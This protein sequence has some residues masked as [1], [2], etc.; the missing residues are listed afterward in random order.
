MSP[1]SKTLPLSSLPLYWTYMC[2]EGGGAN[3]RD[4]VSRRV[5]ACVRTPSP[6]TRAQTHN[7]TKRAS[8]GLPHHLLHLQLLHDLGVN[9]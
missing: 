4:C 9:V 8:A 6:I 1:E 2:V 3:E 7:G 5:H